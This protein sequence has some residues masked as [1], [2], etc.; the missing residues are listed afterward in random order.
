MLDAQA[1]LRDRLEAEPARFLARELEGLL[2]EAR[3]ALGAFVGADADGLAFVPNATTG[4]NTVL[5]SVDLSAGDEI[6][7]TDHTYNACRNAVDAVGGARGGQCRR[8]DAAVP[9]GGAGSRC[10]RRCSLGWD[11]GRGWRSSTT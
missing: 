8:G 4:V 6:L 2:D 10:W 9:P 3:R 11:R 5:R 1:R 7:A